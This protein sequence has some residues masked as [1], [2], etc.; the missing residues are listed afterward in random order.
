MNPLNPDELYISAYSSPT[1]ARDD[2]KVILSVDHELGVLHARYRLLAAA[3]YAVRSACDGAQALGIFAVEKI[4]LVL[5]DYALPGMD[6][7]QVAEAMKSNLPHVPIV[8]VSAAEVPAHYLLICNGHDRK[9]RWPKTAAAYDTP[10]LL[11][12]L[13]DTNRLVV[14]KAFWRC[15]PKT[16]YRPDSS[17][18]EE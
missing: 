17:P 2:R 9:G 16:S 1:T 3:G 11:P 18:K 5:L 14:R 12:C 10:T 8:M 13:I 15:P 7:G 6:G 4:D